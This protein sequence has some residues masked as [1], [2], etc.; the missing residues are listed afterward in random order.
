MANRKPGLNPH[1]W[2]RSS[3]WDP[4]SGRGGTR[5]T[6]HISLLSVRTGRRSRPMATDVRRTLRGGSRRHNDRG[7]Y[8]IHS[9]QASEERARTSRQS[10]IEETDRGDLRAQARQQGGEPA[11]GGKP[12]AAKPSPQ[13][14]SRT[15]RRWLV[16]S[17]HVG[18]CTRRIS[19]ECRRNS[20]RDAVR[21][22]RRQTVEIR[23]AGAR[24]PRRDPAGRGGKPAQGCFPGV[25][26]IGVVA[27]FRSASGYAPAGCDGHGTL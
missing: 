23:A 10:E 13:R 21:A 15:H 3:A 19:R 1:W 24:A 22:V 8:P 11:A 4:G 16:V 6:V 14:R 2:P 7:F 5:A 25:W 17:D 20:R 27:V 26:S 9:S 12:R 18:L